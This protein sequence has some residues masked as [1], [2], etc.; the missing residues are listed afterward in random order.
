VKPVAVGDRGPIGLE[1]T[2]EFDA[3]LPLD[4]PSLRQHLT[5]TPENQEQG[6]AVRVV[7]ADYETETDTPG[8]QFGLATRPWKYH[9]TPERPLEKGTRYFLSVAPGVEPAGGNLATTSSFD[10]QVETYGPLAFEGLEL[11]GAGS[12]GGPDRT[13][14]QRARAAHL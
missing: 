11:V 3:N 4:V 9:V 12:G 7:E 5:L 2:L 10:S 13:L 8:E 14:R 6:V 1:P